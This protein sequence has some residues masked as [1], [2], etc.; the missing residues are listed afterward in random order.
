MNTAHLRHLADK[1]HRLGVHDPDHR[2][3]HSPM[4]IAEQGTEILFRLDVLREGTMEMI[5][6]SEPNG[7]LIYKGMRLCRLTK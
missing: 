3:S 5:V 2:P 1:V 7:K 4:R 6:D